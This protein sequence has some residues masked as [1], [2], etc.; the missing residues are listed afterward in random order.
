MA[1]VLFLL[2]V[3]GGVLW[4]GVTNYRP[5]RLDSSRVAVRIADASRTSPA[6]EPRS[7][8][9]DF[10]VSRSVAEDCR[11]V[12]SYSCERLE[13]ILGEMAAQPVDVEWARRTEARIARVFDGAH[14]G[15]RIRALA[16]RRTRCAIEVASDGD[17][18]RV[19]LSADD[20][21]DRELGWDGATNIAWEV[22]AKTRRWTIVTVATWKKRPSPVVA[23]ST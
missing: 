23:G 4:Y 7:A 10:H 6:S 11:R 22:D 14:A 20:A 19:S 5:P 18:P 16:C 3:E 15:Y 13:E 8:A 12:R 17:Y 2:A 1:A 9:F 21:L